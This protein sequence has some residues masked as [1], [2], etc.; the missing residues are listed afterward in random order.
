M[1]IHPTAIVDKSA[2]LGLGVT[3]GPWSVLGPRVVVGDGTEIRSHALIEKDTVLGRSCRVFPYACLGTDPQDTKYAGEH[4]RLVIGDNVTVRE[5]ATIHRGTK[6]GGGA[7]TV[8]N[9]CL[10]MATCHIAHDCHLEDDVILSSFAVLAGHVSLGAHSTVSGSSAIHQFVR[11]GRH[12]FIGGMSGV[13]KDV[14][15][16]MIIAGLRGSMLLSPNLVGLKRKGFSP[17]AVRAITEAHR[18]L[19]NH[20]PLQGVLDEISERLGDSPEARDIVAF[21]RSSVRGVYR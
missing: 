16:Y 6:N 4:T 5:F 17:E 11:V 10:V 15:P 9:G 13:V 8:G 3:V 19:H 1:G 12:A 2:E 20:R 21:Y 18:L 14:P 7:T